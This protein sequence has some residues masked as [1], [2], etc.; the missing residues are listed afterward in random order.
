ML[1]KKYW[2][3]KF[4]SNEYKYFIFKVFKKKFFFLMKHFIEIESHS[5]IYLLNTFTDLTSRFKEFL[6]ED[7][8]LLKKPL[9]NDIAFLLCIYINDIK[10]ISGILSA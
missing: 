9:A 7:D 5:L 6:K 1:K 8:L 4:T 10:V 2:L 3:K